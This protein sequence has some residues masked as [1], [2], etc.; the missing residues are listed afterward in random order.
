MAR[1][2]LV[3]IAFLPFIGGCDALGIG[4]NCTLELR[5]Q[6]SPADTTIEIGDSFQASVELLTCGGSE[7][8]A[9]VFTWQSNDPS[10]AVVDQQ[11]GRVVGKAPGVTQVAATGRK[12]GAVGGIAVSVEGLDP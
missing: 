3:F 10:I 4:K 5:A 2:R 7:R 6:Y 1:L 8:L 11:T 9:D 12:Y